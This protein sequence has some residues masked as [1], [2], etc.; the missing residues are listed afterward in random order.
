LIC[1]SLCSCVDPFSLYVSVYLRFSVV[2][3][4]TLQAQF[5]EALITMYAGYHPDA[6][7]Q[8]E[9]DQFTPRPSSASAAG[10]V[11]ASSSSKSSPTEKKTDATET[12][13][14]A[15]QQSSDQSLS[16]SFLS[17]ADDNGGSE[18]IDRNGHSQLE[19]KIQLL[20]DRL[21]RQSVQLKEQSAE[22]DQLR[23]LVKD[24][25][26]KAERKSSHNES[27]KSV[28]FEDEV[29]EIR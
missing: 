12:S 11:N 3:L 10:T 7:W 4:V 16:H 17:S 5:N 20:V 8:E 28:E 1:I 21:E 25:N 24:S 18:G 29:E 9:G 15:Q 26:Y 14:T 27:Q 23:S 19:G 22:L 6:F 13:T 2:R